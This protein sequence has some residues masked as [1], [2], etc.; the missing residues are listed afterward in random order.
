MVPLVT[1][2]HGNL[3]IL[4]F[5]GADLQY[6]AALDKRTGK[7]VWRTERS[8]DF[9]DLGADGKPFRDGDMRKGLD[10]ARHQARRQDAV[11][12]HRRD[13]LLRI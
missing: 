8:V 6:M 13:G 4:T 5:D 2:R 10:T 11:D 12:Q 7:T 9:Q 3:L 1:N